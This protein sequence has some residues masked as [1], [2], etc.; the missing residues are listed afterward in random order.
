MWWQASLTAGKGTWQWTDMEKT[1]QPLTAMEGDLNIFLKDVELHG[2]EAG[3]QCKQRAW[4]IQIQRPI[5]GHI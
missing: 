3:L 2:R 4:R 1:G 5:F